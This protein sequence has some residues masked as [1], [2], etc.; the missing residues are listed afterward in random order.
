MNEGKPAASKPP[1][2]KRIGSCLWR[3][4]LIALL[5]GLAPGCCGIGS[6]PSV[7]QVQQWMSEIHEGDSADK[8]MA[9]LKSKG[10]HVDDNR[11]TY[12]N[13]YGVRHTDACIFTLIDKEVDV[14]AQ[15]NADDRVSN[16]RVYA[17]ADGP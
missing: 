12:H 16:V 8:A 6:G 5:L 7:P 3:P 10:F 4:S 15:L 9:V 17:T 1:M 13:I 14:E 11:L 2:R